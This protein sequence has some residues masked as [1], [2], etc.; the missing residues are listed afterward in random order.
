MRIDCVN[1]TGFTSLYKGGTIRQIIKN[2]P[3]KE[4]VSELR[5]VECAVRK[6]NL[7]KKENV[8]IILGYGEADGFYGVISSKTQ[9][10]PMNPSSVCKVSKDQESIKTF[11]DWVEEWDKAYSPEELKKFRNL[12]NFIA[13]KLAKQ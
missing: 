9:G 8:D 6:N 11:S 1:Q 12:M 2:N 13:A 10:T 7:H 5:G 4:F 3:T